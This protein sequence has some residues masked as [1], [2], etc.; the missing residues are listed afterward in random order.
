MARGAAP[1]RAKVSEL[2]VEAKKALSV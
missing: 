1:D 2:E